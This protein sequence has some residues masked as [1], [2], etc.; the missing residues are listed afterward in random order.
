MSLFHTN[1]HVSC[2]CVIDV[3]IFH[4][5]LTVLWRA[6][7]CPLNE[8]SQFAS[9]ENYELTN[10]YPDGVKELNCHRVINDWI[11]VKWYEKAT[12]YY[13][14]ANWLLAQLVA[15]EW[16]ITQDVRFLCWLISKASKKIK[17]M[18]DQTIATNVYR[19]CCRKRKSD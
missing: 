7:G 15:E 2:Y 9:L 17:H 5:K 1:A 4:M 12:I 8:D 13:I 6:G 18:F 16:A 19:L 10:S 3:W 14:S 11:I